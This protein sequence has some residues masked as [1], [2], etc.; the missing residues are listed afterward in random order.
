MYSKLIV[1]SHDSGWSPLTL[2][3][4]QGIFAAIVVLHVQVGEDHLWVS[5]VLCSPHVLVITTE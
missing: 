2:E 4:S 1:K 5:D 3:W